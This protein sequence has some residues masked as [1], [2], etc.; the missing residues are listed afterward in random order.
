MD[1]ISTFSA[2]GKKLKTGE[3]YLACNFTHRDPETDYNNLN[4]LL[5]FHNWKLTLIIEFKTASN[6]WSFKDCEKQLQS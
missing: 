2:S 5:I 3:M 6:S 4:W 1:K